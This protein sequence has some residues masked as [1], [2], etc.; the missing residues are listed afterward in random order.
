MFF[1]FFFGPE[2]LKP[3]GSSLSSRLHVQRHY[4]LQ[5]GGSRSRG[6]FLQTVKYCLTS[7][8][9]SS[10]APPSFASQPRIHRLQILQP[11]SCVSL[12]TNT[13]KHTNIACVDAASWQ[14][15]SHC[16]VY[17][18]LRIILVRKR[19]AATMKST[20]YLLWEKHPLVF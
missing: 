10:K 17:I 20:E 11:L 5:A 16:R 7:S 1:F 15:T 12:H 13:H 18:P 9:Y 14:T 19:T 3:H 8:H 4:R 2:L 6:L